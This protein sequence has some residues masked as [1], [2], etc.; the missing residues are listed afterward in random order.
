[1]IFAESAEDQ[2]QSK[3]MQSH[4]NLSNVHVEA[5]E[6][7]HTVKHCVCLFAVSCIPKTESQVFETR[8]VFG[9]SCKSLRAAIEVNTVVLI[10]I[11]VA[12]LKTDAIEDVAS[13]PR[14]CWH[15]E[16]GQY[17]ST[18]MQHESLVMHYCVNSLKASNRVPRNCRK[19]SASCSSDLR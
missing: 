6:P 4:A 12:L 13:Y 16:S 3:V 11:H 2:F 18:P 9:I 7:V 17:V 1:M 5:C 10:I 15:R 8:S 19:K 14:T